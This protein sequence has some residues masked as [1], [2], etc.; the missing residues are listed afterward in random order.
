MPARSDLFQGI[1][2]ARR[3]SIYHACGYGSAD[4]SGPHIGIANAFN[5]AAPGHAHL[6]RIAEAVKSGVW[7]AGGVPFEFNCPS[8]CGAVCVG[9]PHLRYELAI[10]DVIAASIEIVAAEHLF[11]GLVLLSSCDSIIPGQILGAIRSGLPTIFVTGGPMLPG[12]YRGRALLQNELDELVLSRDAADGAHDDDILEMEKAA[13][14]T[15]GACP[16]MGTANTMQALTEA[17]GIA[18]SGSSTIP[19][20]YAEKLIVAR[21]SGRRVVEMVREDL[22]IRKILTRDALR[23][24]ARVDMALGG[25]TNAVLHL[26]AFARELGLSFSLGDFDKA[27][28]EVPCICTII[29]NGPHDVTELHEAG[30]VPAVCREIRDSLRPDAFT[31]DG[32]S[33]GEL[34]DKAAN[35]DTRIIRR[36]SEADRSREGLAVLY[37]NLSPRGAI[38]RP[39]SFPPRSTR[40]SGRAR[41]FDSDEEAYRAIMGGKI[42][43]GD[44]VVVRYEG[45]KGAPGM[46]EVMLSTDA[47]CGKGLSSTVA[48]VTD[49]RFSGFTRGTAI[50]HVSPEAM[51]GGP[52]ACVNDGDGIEIDV[53]NRLMTLKVDDKRLALRMRDWKRPKPKADTGVLAQYA[54]LAEQ[55]DRGAMMRIDAA[56]GKESL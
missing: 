9:T 3:R 17:I 27:S 22:S 12:R 29:P 19:G 47:L 13:N 50:G 33:I 10:R 40:F 2:G 54:S 43:E 46:R 15:P 32:V 44:V 36:L 55:A 1:D 31:V 14:P 34:M 28:R 23:N 37:G 5:E 51:A 7:Q 48:L 20:V 21:R 38:C 41:C 11:D 45:P 52:I 18:P 4:L 24:G 26:L 30:G 16:L 49:G 6:R 42:A 53:P 39:S 56:Q 35:R 25:S 8:T